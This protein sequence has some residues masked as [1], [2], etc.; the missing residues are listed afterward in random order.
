MADYDFIFAPPTVSVE[1]AL[2]PAHNNLNSLLLLEQLGSRHGL[3][4]WVQDTREV[5]PEERKRINRMLFDVFYY[6]MLPEDRNWASY[7]E[8][9]DHLAA[10]DAVT[11]R[12]RAIHRLGERIGADDPTAMLA[13][14]TLFVETLK[15]FFLSKSKEHEEEFVEERILGTL[16]DAHPLL[17]DPPAMQRIIVE[18]LRAM[19]EKYLAA[20]WE[21]IQPMLQESIDAFQQLDFAD[22]TAIEATRMV[23]GRDLGGIWPALDTAQKI[24]FI[25]SAHLGP[26]VSLTPSENLPGQVYLF[27]GARVPEGFEAKS[28]ALSRSELLVRLSALADET[29]LAILELLT[30]HD[31]LCA[32]D[33]MTTLQLSQ[34][35]ASR[36]LRQLTATGYLIERRRDVAKCYSLNMERFDDTLKALRYFMRG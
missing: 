4:D 27:Y 26:Y 25:P 11:L 10:Q 15:E 16:M 7:L 2:A 33:I 29:R 6:A 8:Y 1:F 17:N 3:G 18:H 9:I 30:E 13:N 31:E 35:S 12:D 32:Q 34:S 21:R 5:L 14:R 23:T 19:W 36:H 22:K 28:P 24:L 20:E